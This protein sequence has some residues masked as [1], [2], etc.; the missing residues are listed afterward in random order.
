MTGKDEYREIAYHALKWVLSTMREDGNIPYILA[1]GKADWA[2][3]G[4]AKNDYELWEDMTYGTAGYVGE[5]ILAFD[6]HCDQPQW[7][8]W[9]EKAVQPNI[10][11]LLKTQLPD[12]TWS[13]LPQDQLGSDALPGRHRLSDLVLRAC[14]PRPAYRQ[15]GAAI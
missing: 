3:R 10:E 9:I 8:A 4:D 2:K 11:F 5:G 7:R 13:K 15:G 6:L 12:G 1:W 14:Q